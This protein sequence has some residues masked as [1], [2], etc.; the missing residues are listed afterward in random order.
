[1]E[2]IHIMKDMLDKARAEVVNLENDQHLEVQPYDLEYTERIK[3]WRSAAPPESPYTEAEEV[4]EKMLIHYEV[5][6]KLNSTN[7]SLK[8]SSFRPEFS[9]QM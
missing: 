9:S 2:H 6:N 4:L 8:F 5:S 7:S 3:Q 1:M